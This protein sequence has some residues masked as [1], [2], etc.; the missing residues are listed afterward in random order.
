MNFVMT[1]KA[2]LYGGRVLRNDL[3]LLAQKNGH[4]V[5][6]KVFYG[7]DYLV[8][9]SPTVN[10]LKHK[11]A[12]MYKVPIINTEAFVDMMGGELE[13]VDTGIN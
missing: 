9:D 10:T 7:T 12:T 2:F 1:G 13:L 11:M 4:I 6:P 8:T 5:T 3:I